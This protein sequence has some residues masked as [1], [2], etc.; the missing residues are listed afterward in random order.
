M[1]T[2]KETK[3]TFPTSLSQI[4]TLGGPINDSYKI[5]ILHPP[6]LVVLVVVG[7]GADSNFLIGPPKVNIY[8]I[9]VAM[10]VV[11]LDFLA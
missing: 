9:Y 2:R 1:R 4:S 3:L 11:L 10:E 8:G 5:S 7:W 6:L